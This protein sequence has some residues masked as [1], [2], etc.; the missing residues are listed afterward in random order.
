WVNRLG[1]SGESAEK[2]RTPRYDSTIAVLD[3]AGAIIM[4]GR[5]KEGHSMISDAYTSYY[6]RVT[7]AD[8]LLQP[9]ALAGVGLSEDGRLLVVGGES[10]SRDNAG[11]LFAPEV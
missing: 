1:R 8:D 11:A 3:V 2:L 4:G 6:H 9:R 10:D 5:T 7:E